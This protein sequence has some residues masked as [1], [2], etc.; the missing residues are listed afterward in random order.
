MSSELLGAV[1]GLISA[2]FYGS[3]DFTGGFNSK[4]N[5]LYAVVIVS[6]STGLI[7]YL[8][9]AL[10]S[11]E[12]MPPLEDLVYAAIGGTIGL[13][14]LLALYRSLSLGHMGIT[15]PIAGVITA[16]LPVI[17]TAISRGFPDMLT[18]VGFAIGLVAV[19]LVAQSP[20]SG[21]IDRRAIL[22]PIVAGTGFGIAFLFFVRG[23]ENATFF[24]LAAA[25]ATTVTLTT[26][27]V[28]ITRKPFTIASRRAVPLIIFGG[29]LD[30]GGNAFFVTAAHLGRPDVAAVLS[31]MYPAATIALAAILLKERIRRI[32]WVGIVAALVAIVL[33]VA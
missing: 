25:R 4:N 15:A 6:Q 18:L 22:L 7:L 31:S 17:F 13:I 1:Y 16:A 29:M 3:G 23:S 11:G 14:G 28:L 24:P 8:V 30:S 20:T 33:I 9:L 12:A 19:W 27:F 21:H 32:Q 10:I 2:V 26:L 5:S